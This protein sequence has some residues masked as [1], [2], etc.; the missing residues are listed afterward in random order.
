IAQYY[1][2]SGSLAPRLGN[3]HSTI[4]PYQVFESADGHVIIAVGNDRQFARLAQHLGEDTWVTDERFATNSA[5]VKNR[6]VL[7]PL[8]AAYISRHPT[9]HWVA[10]LQDIDVPVG[11][12]N[13]ME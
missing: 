6:G 9:A 2:T 13:D 8:I 1:L 5:R 4:V 10:A 12:V 3:A 7:I 11:P